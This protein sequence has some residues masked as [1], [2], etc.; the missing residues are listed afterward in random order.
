MT[1]AADTFSFP[2][3]TGKSAIA[4]SDVR[5]F[6]L[7]PTEDSPNVNVV[8]TDPRGSKVFQINK[9]GLKS[10]SL[11][12]ATAAAVSLMTPAQ[13]QSSG[14][15]TVV[16]T[17]SRIPQQGLISA[18]PVT[19]V[20][21]QEI[22]NEGTTNVEN[23]LNNLPSVFADQGSAASNAASGTASV[24][25]RDLSPKRTLVLIDGKRLMPGDP[26]ALSHATGGVADIDVIAAALVE[27]V[28]VETGGASAVYG[29]DAV[30]GVVNFILRKDFEGV[31]VDGQYSIAENG[32]SHITA[33]D[34]PINAGTPYPGAPKD[35]WDG[36]TGDVTVLLGVNSADGKGNVTLYGS[37]ESQQKVLE[38]QRDFSACSAAVNFPSGPGAGNPPSN[39]F[40]CVGSSTTRAA[41]SRAST[42]AMPFP[43]ALPAL[44]TRHRF[45]WVRRPQA[46]SG[47][48]GRRF[49]FAPFNYLQ[50]P[51]IRYNFGAQGHYDISNRAEFYSLRDVHGR[52]HDRAGRTGRCL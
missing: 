16:V 24:N 6:G 46:R 45:H 49:N 37:V 38:S 15:E 19:A 35:V 22:K 12:G 9:S 18:T 7:R 1:P 20:S 26:D 29:S 39:G 17:G 48:R 30:A 5:T 4:G 34:F 25:L 33:A 13:A 40:A 2:Y 50:R 52:P 3:N 11:G 47:P 44:P 28:E 36:G 51:D 41:S 23:L 31:E 8:A 14:V 32:N 21:A 27:R 10:I 43:L 42:P